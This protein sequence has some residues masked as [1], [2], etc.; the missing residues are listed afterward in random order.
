[1]P[2]SRHKPETPQTPEEAP[3]ERKAAWLDPSAESAAPERTEEPEAPSPEAAALPAPEPAEAVLE[4]ELEE[5]EEP[6]PPAPEPDEPAPEPAA[7]AP[8]EPPEPLP[9]TPPEARTTMD[10]KTMSLI[11]G[12]KR[13]RTENSTLLA[14]DVAWNGRSYEKLG[15]NN[16]LFRT[17]KGNYF[18]QHQTTWDYESD[19][20]VPLARDQALAVYE[21]LPV[22]VVDLEAAFPGI[23]IEE[24]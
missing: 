19:S 5:E 7:A 22:K 1:M 3:P 21:E 9:A 14:S 23:E 11:V 10:P 13:Y 4:L 24:A 17:S 12:G 8:T 6:A 18:M 20:L 16:F 15:R 2:W